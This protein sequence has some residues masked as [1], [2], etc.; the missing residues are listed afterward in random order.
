LRCS[1]KI[2]KIV[3]LESKQ[4]PKRASHGNSSG[5]LSSSLMQALIKNKASQPQQDSTLDH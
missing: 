3:D 5:I 1:V 4:H 2:I